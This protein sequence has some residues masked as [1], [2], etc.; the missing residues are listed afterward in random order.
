MIRSGALRSLITASVAGAVALCRLASAQGVMG[1]WS[2][3]QAPPAPQLAPV[4][5]NP[6]KTALLVMDFGAI[7]CNAQ[8]V[9]R[10]TGDLPHVRKLLAE[11]RAHRMLVVYT[12]FP[13]E[14]AFVKSIEPTRDEPALVARGA[15]KFE[16][17]QLS[18]ILASHGIT[19]VIT[20]GVVA[21]GAV[22]YTAFG[23]ASRGYKVIVPV[24]AIPGRS[25]YAEQSTIW[26]LANDPGLGTRAGVTLTS[27]GLISF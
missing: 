13:H 22:L 5:V 18:R 6:R 19:T 9:A 14:G 11:A 21:N 27:S 7:L 10:C 8:R 17:S 26:N 23:A 1:D 4:A 2:S 16:G 25:E 24:D 20:T 12:S 3:I 15:D